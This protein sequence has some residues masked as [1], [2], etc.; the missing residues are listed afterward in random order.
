[1]TTQTLPI[2]NAGQ[3][4]IF[5]RTEML[6]HLLIEQLQLL[7]Q[8][9]VTGHRQRWIGCQHRA[10]T[11]NLKLLTHCEFHKSQRWTKSS[12]GRPK[13]RAAVQLIRISSARSCRLPYSQHAM[14]LVDR[15]HAGKV[16][17]A[18]DSA[19]CNVDDNVKRK[20]R[21]L[22][23]ARSDRTQSPPLS[24]SISRAPQ[25]EQ[26]LVHHDESNLRHEFTAPFFFP[27]PSRS[28]RDGSRMITDVVPDN[29]RDRAGV[30]RCRQ[31]I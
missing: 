29:D 17:I 8:Y 22:I 23:I 6:Q 5:G 11:Y 24:S 21:I 30:R 15:Q 25:I 3:S 1:M 7:L 4:D 2:R 14:Q 31:S 12:I 16:V 28:P 26:R 10:S 13:R 27:P 18:G 20:G 9:S 19:E